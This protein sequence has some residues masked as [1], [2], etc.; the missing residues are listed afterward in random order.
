MNDASEYLHAVS[1]L[2]ESIKEAREKETD[3][4][5]IQL[6]DEI[7]NPVA[8]T[9]PQDVAP[10]FVACLSAKENSL[11]QWRAYGRGEGGFSIGFDSDKLDL[12][13]SKLGGF[14]SP[15]IYD[16]DQQAALVRQF[17]SWALLEY[18]KLAASLPLEA[19]EGHRK[20][21]A[22]MLLWR[23]AVAA[24]IIKN[25]AFA[26]E[27]EW[28]LIHLPKW[29]ENIRFLPRPTG[30]V[31]YLELKLGL[32]EIGTPEQI[33]RLGRSLPDRLPIEVLWSGPGRATDTS[34]LA[35]RTLLEQLNYFGVKLEA[36]KIPY[37]VG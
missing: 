9:R 23:V 12:A 4:L 35:G 34:L 21:W 36:S 20:A 25:P 16:R 33:A 26:E 31:P 32:S 8:L 11:N 27:E 28:R 6:L 29:K 37:R 22:H 7:Q 18:P 24:P 5:R 17:L 19:Q 2:S 30:L 1:L 10:Y 3:A 13:N 14:L 15:A